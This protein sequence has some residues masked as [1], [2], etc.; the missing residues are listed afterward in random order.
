[1]PGMSGFEV[2]SRLKPLTQ[3]NCSRP[4]PRPT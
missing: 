3:A 2:T 1:L 4:V